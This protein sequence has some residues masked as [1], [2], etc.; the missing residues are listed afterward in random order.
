MWG[1]Y[2]CYSDIH[3]NQFWGG[4]RERKKRDDERDREKERERQREREREKPG[5]T[6][7][8]IDRYNDLFSTV[9]T[10]PPNHPTSPP[11]L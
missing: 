11:D 4:E 9:P 6:F 1:H 5:I 7:I 10:Q 2:N 3:N 8:Y